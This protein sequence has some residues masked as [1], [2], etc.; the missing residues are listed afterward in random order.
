M[1]R[2][3]VTLESKQNLSSKNPEL[4]THIELFVNEEGY[5]TKDSISEVFEELQKFEREQEIDVLTKAG[6]VAEAKKIQAT[7]IPK[8]QEA[9]KIMMG[10]RYIFCIAGSGFM[11]KRGKMQPKDVIGM[12]HPSDTGFYQRNGFLDE[13][14]IQTFLKHDDFF[15]LDEVTGERVITRE[16][17]S[18][19][20]LESKALADERWKDKGCFLKKIGP[21]ANVGEFDFMFRFFYS[22]KDSSGNAVLTDK[23]FYAFYK[24][25]IALYAKKYPHSSLAAVTYFNLGFKVPA[26]K[27]NCCTWATNG[28]KGL[29]FSAGSKF[30]SILPSIHTSSHVSQAEDREEEV[31]RVHK[32]KRV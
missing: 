8:L 1:Q 17:V 26:P 14:L 3:L 20:M 10:A 13:N 31:S 7:P 25:T 30:V 12:M 29:L 23:D 28:V 11:A 22:Y 9:Q 16:R 24:N 4:Q 15:K 6:K 2:K 19:F 32:R 27:E 21:S 5:I 18:K